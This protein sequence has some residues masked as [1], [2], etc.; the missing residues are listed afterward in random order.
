MVSTDPSVHKTLFVQVACVFSSFYCTNT[1]EHKVV[2]ICFIDHNK[3]VT[4]MT[5]TY[6]TPHLLSMT[7]SFHHRTKECVFALYD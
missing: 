2:F 3:H 4:K 7:L 1:L 5:G 6:R